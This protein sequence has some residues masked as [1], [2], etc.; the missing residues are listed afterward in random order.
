V[1]VL[2]TGWSSFVHGE[3]TTGDVLGMQRV[4][5][6]LDGAGVTCE[7]AWS[8]VLRPGALTLDAADPR[9][10]TLVVFACGPV[11]GRQVR[12][13]HERFARCR[14]IAVGVTVHDPADPAVT[15]FDVV[16]GRDAAG[17]AGHRDLASTVDATPVP[18]VGVV[19]APGQPEYRERR[20]HELVHER[21]A[22][23]L[24]EQDCARWRWTPGWTRAGGAL[25][26]PPTSWTRCC[27]AWTRWSPAG[28]TGWCWPCAAASRRWPSTRS[29]AAAK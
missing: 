1:R 8:P 10:Y 9:R 7:L 24:T 27:A 22:A 2:V 28:A 20:R 15:G 5:A 6:A 11:H 23:W 16:L 13:L 4:Q 3:A 26:P 21:L 25:A 14:R 29:P 19:L 12:W 17:R 18:V